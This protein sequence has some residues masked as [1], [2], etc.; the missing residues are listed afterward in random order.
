MSIIFFAKDIVTF[1]FTSE[2]LPAVLPL[3]ILIIG[4]VIFGTIISTG[5][6]FASVGNVDLTLKISAINAICAVLLNLILIPIYG[7]IGAAM[8]TTAAYIL[9]T[10]FYVYFLK[11]SLAIKLDASWFTKL[12]MLVGM[13]VALFYVFCFLNYYLSSVI[14]LLLYAIVIIKY[15]ITKEDKTYFV[16]LIK[17]LYKAIL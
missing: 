12:G 13:L 9:S 5:G 10:I 15:F 4:T 16:S 14:T 6:I 1:L 7:I 3:T 11:A 8:A 17:L 2:F